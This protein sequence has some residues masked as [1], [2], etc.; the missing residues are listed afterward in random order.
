M[1]VDQQ[2]RDALRQNWEQAKT[3][4]QGQFPALRED[5]LQQQDPERLVQAI[6]QRTGQSQSQVE[7]QVRQVAQQVAQMNQGMNQGTNVSGTNPAGMS[8]GQTVPPQT[9]VQPGQTGQMPGQSG[10]PQQP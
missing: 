7:Q 1:A 6:S 2:T 10:R 3:Q 4:F 5:D 9:Q 8:Q